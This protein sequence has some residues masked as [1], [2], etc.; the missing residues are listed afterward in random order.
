MQIPEFKVVKTTDL[1][2]G[3]IDEI[4]TLFTNVFGKTRS[5]ETFLNQSVQNPFGYSYHSL[6]MVGG[7]IKGLNSFV[8]SYYLINGKRAIFANSTDSMIEKAYRDFF[9]Y[10]DLIEAGY[11]VMKSEGVKFVY[12]Y[13]N[14]VSYPVAIKGRIFKDI[15]RMKI[16]CLP[17][18]IGGLFKGLK[19]FNFCSEWLCRGY[20]KCNSI[21]ASKQLEKLP[22]VKEAATF[23]PTRYRRNDGNYLSTDLPHGGKAYYKIMVYE[24]KRTAF[25]I[26]VEQ[27][28]AAAFCEVVREIIRKHRKEIDLILYP[29]RLHFSHSGLI[30]LPRKL[31]PKNFHLVGKA[32]DKDIASEVWDV[33][34][35]DTNLSNYDLI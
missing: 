2:D 35:W 6:M 3:Q 15:G 9:N 26:D 18:H 34:M 27:K 20:V 13:P 11:S 32:L 24:G 7:T 10:K 23:N 12:G 31:E 5:R 16:Y 30:C 14:D 28:S 25:L 21:L 33:E 17:L 1:T 4:N 19:T 8:P 29:G 22:V